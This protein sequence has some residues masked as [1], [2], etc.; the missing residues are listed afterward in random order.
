MTEDSQGKKKKKNMFSYAVSIRVLIENM[1]SL[2]DKV[3][4]FG[5]QV[6]KHF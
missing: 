3:L 4:N 2:N 6:N 1:W 5:G